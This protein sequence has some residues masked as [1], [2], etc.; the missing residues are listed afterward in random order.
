MRRKLAF[1]RDTV[2][3][4]DADLVKVVT[5]CPRILEYSTDQTLQP[6]LAFLRS[7]G[8]TG[9][10]VAKVV[11]RA[12]M[13]MALSVQDTLQ[14]RADFL[15]KELL[16]PEGAL[17]KLIVRHPQVLT[18]SEDMMRQRIEFLSGECGLE[19]A[20]IAKAVL[21]HPQV[22]H[23]KIDSMKERLDYLRSVGMS[24]PQVAGAV[25]RFPQV[26]SL[27]VSTNMAPKWHYLV[28]HLGG[29]IQALCN[30]PGY[31]S[32][33]LANRIVARHRYLQQL[34]GGEAPMPFPL[35]HFKLSDKEF[36]IKVAGTSLQEYEAFKEKLEAEQAVAA[37]AATSSE[38]EDDGGDDGPLR[39][40]GS[41]S[42]TWTVT[43]TTRP[44][45][46]G[47]LV[48]GGIGGL[49]QQRG[50][51]IA[52]GPNAQQRSGPLVRRAHPE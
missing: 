47:G 23:Y 50:T 44:L 33:S 40:G 24:G 15:S 8:V 20:D 22:L 13:T 3:I 11:I 36:A 43:P 35:G 42:E 16:L 38:T 7:V 46:V 2:G 28:E 17:G 18:C 4:A 12:P 45:P 41:S 51:G 27:S 39:Q 26:F 19:A 30:Y 34:R 14:P 25:A 48:N 29:G 52:L 21:A 32:L 10:D 5:K 31:F 49:Y 6:R 9:S 1:L 37:E